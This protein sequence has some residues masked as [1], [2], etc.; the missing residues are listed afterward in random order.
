MLVDGVGA[1]YSK[2]RSP[3]VLRKRGIPVHE[4]LGHLVP[5]RMAYMNL[6]NHRKLL[7]VDGQI[8]F[9][10]GLN[11]REGAILDV[12]STH[13]IRDLHF[14][15]EG[16]VVRHLAEAFAKDWVFSCGEELFSS[17]WFPVLESRGYAA[18]RGVSDGPDDDFEQLHSTFLAALAG[19]D[20]S[21]RIMTPYFL[22]DQ[23]LLV[24]LSTPRL[25]GEFAMDVLIPSQSNLRTVGWAMLL[26]STR[27]ST[28]AVG[29]G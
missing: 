2:P 4:F 9:T 8:G 1:A 24:R 29:S 21:V 25:S 27:F 5:W 19:A 14:Q 23:A 16:P 20:R 26:N 17:G 13:P 3:H 11:I 18:A 7:V 22:P 15:L 10:G 28:P 12:P 6:R